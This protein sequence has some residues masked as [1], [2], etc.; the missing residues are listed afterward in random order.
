[1]ENQCAAQQSH[2]LQGQTL[3]HPDAWLT[4]QPCT[5]QP[6]GISGLGQGEFSWAVPSRQSSVTGSCGS[7]LSCGSCSGAVLGPYVSWSCHSSQQSRL[8][9][10]TQARARA[11]WVQY[12]LPECPNKVSECA[13]ETVPALGCRENLN[14]PSPAALV[15]S[16]LHPLQV[17]RLVPK[18]RFCILVPCQ[19]DKRVGKTVT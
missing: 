4:S 12:F 16:A 2:R 10:G 6:S 7:L 11:W 15:C 3:L 9:A 14:S 19:E 8:P 1:M 13:A 18:F 17:R 5:D